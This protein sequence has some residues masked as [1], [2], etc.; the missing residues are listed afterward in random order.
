MDSI[1]GREIRLN[2]WDLAYPAFYFDSLTAPQE[3]LRVCAD[4][5]RGEDL[6]LARIL[7]ALKAN[8]FKW[9]DELSTPPAIKNLNGVGGGVSIGGG[10][11]RA[12]QRDLRGTHLDQIN[13]ETQIHTLDHTALDFC[14]FTKCNLDLHGTDPKYIGLVPFLFYSQVSHASFSECRF[15]NISW[16]TSRMMNCIFYG[17]EFTDIVFNRN[18]DG[19][20]ERL[21]FM[22]C[23][24]ENVDFS[25]IKL[26]SW[27]F[28]G[29]CSFKNLIIGNQTVDLNRPMANEILEF[30]R[31]NDVANWSKRKRL[32]G[33][34]STYD[35]KTGISTT[36]VRHRE[37]D[38]PDMPIIKYAQ[39]INCYE[40]LSNLYLA[41]T[42]TNT[43]KRASGLSSEFDFRFAWFVDEAAL[44]V[45]TKKHYPIIF[46]KTIFGREIMGY[47]NNPWRPLRCWLVVVLC[48][49]IGYM[50]FGVQ[51]MGVPIRRVLQWDWPQFGET[52]VDYA[53]CLYF[54]VVTATTVGF[55]DF[56]P[57]SGM[58]RFLAATEALMAAILIPIFTVCLTRRYLRK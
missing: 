58:S 40:G 7:T 6:R 15:K 16:H 57:L 56:A 48:F 42:D 30:C 17:C 49:P 50:F 24:F 54:S 21:F 33:L 51:G 13:I 34:T 20:Y 47:G 41:L 14:S 19:E 52:L 8:A 26:N 10:P 32:V 18:L 29:P 36:A 28:W 31:R 45:A 46:M 4:R 43:A 38:E 5:W 12:Y 3:Q 37:P 1:K 44:C 22:N 27:C 39:T 23:K 25:R 2:D 9:D 55:G 53:K 35:G 11:P